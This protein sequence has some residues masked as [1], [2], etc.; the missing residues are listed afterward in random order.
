MWWDTSNLYHRRK[1]SIWWFATLKYPIT[2]TVNRKFGLLFSRLSST[3]WIPFHKIKHILKEVNPISLFKD[4]NWTLASADALPLSLPSVCA[5]SWLAL[6]T[7]MWDTKRGSSERE[8]G[9]ETPWWKLKL[10]HSHN[11]CVR[12]VWV[13]PNKISPR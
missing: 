1:F 5:L 3:F 4:T 10:E 6:C 7:I 13:V 8:W 12:C 9:G 11:M 2:L